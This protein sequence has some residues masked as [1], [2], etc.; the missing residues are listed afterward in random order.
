L[1]FIA[2][3]IPIVGL[4]LVKNRK[5]KVIIALS[6]LATAVTTSPFWLTFLKAAK[7]SRISSYVSLEWLLQPGN[8]IDKIT[9]ILIP[10][11]LLAV[12]FFYFST[13]ANKKKE[14]LF[15]SPILLTSVFFASRIAVF[16]PL[17]NRPAPDTYNLLLIFFAVFLFLKTDYSKLKMEKYIQPIILIAVISAITISIIFTPFFQPHTQEVKDTLEILKSVNQKFRIS[18]TPVSVSARAINAYA[19]LYLN[20]STPSGWASLNLPDDYLDSL[21]RQTEALNSKNCAELKSSMMA[22][23]TKELL[24]FNEYCSFLKSCGF[25]QKKTINNVCLYKVY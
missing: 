11:L 18:A 7:T 25:T 20:L 17:F 1:V 15:Y 5:E 13:A 2:A 10:L 12:F 23:D 6:V 16:I 21:N 22:L 8:T 19:P 9:S 4:F 3:S 24:V 14:L